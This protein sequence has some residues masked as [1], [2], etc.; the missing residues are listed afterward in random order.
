MSKTRKSPAPTERQEQ[1]VL[2][3]WLDMSG[4]LWS[5]TAN[6][7][8]RDAITGRH[9]KLSG[10]KPG[11]PDIIIFSIPDAL[12]ELGFRGVAIELKRRTGGRAS[13]TQLEWIAALKANGWRARVCHGA[14]DAIAWLEDLGY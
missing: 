14:D 2:A 6:G 1:Q 7:S 3:Q 8:N 11:L 9:L 13:P 4:I 5:A 12:S 10:V